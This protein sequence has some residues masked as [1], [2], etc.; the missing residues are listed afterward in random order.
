[1]IP[2]LFHAIWTQG[3]P[4]DEYEPWI[5]SWE[6]LNPG[7]KHMLWSEATYSDLLGPLREVHDSTP[8]VGKA[9]HW[10]QKADIAGKAILHELGG[11]TMCLDFEA[12]R[13]MGD[14]F[15]GKDHVVLWWESPGQLSNGMIGAPPKHPAVTQTVEEIPESCR[16]Q[17]ERGL[18]INYGASPKFLHR[19]WANRPDLE[20]RPANEIYPYLWFDEPP[21]SYGDSYAVHY[22]KATWK[23]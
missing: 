15:A 13:P 8:Y 6:R 11:V 22:W 1:M 17:R 19:V 14:I 16:V 12:L 18:S 2:K 23:Q 20:V 10:A 5:E 3:E 21:A 9:A 4:P 7:W